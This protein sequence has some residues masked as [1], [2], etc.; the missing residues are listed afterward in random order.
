MPNSTDYITNEESNITE[1][2]NFVEVDASEINSRLIER[3]EEYTGEV[4][5][6]GDERREFLQGFS[7]ELAVILNYINETG[8]GNLLRYAESL[9]LD[10]LGDLYG[11]QR[12]N[13]DKATTTL[14]IKIS[15]AQSTDI[16]IP[17]GTRVSPDGEHFFETDAAVIFLAN[18][19]ELTRTVTATAVEAG[20]EYN[21]FLAGQ[22]NKLV[23]SNEYVEYVKNVDTS[24]G[25]TD[26]E[27][28]DEYRDRLRISPFNFAVAGPAEAY[29]SIAMGVSGEI[30]DVYVHSPSAGVV[31]IVVIKA[32]GEIPTVDDTLLIDILNACSD[33]TVRPLTDFVQVVPATAVETSINVEYYVANNDMSV[34][35]AIMTAIEEYKAWQT[36]KIGRDIN[37]DELNNR[38]RAAGAGRVVITSPEYKALEKYEIAKITEIKATYAGSINM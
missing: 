1:E 27:T 33:K 5:Y 12:L 37:P 13:G 32:G 36:S 19:D 25:G 2:I 11:N 29:R 24:S 4:L 17:Q 10:A 3:F 8:R 16:L 34:I 6:P 35:P 18:T 38:L 21:E 14:E 20:E 9:E 31:E 22:I 7:Y 28:D 26:A 15:K 30:E 23:E